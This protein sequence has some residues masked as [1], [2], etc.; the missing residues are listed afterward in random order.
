MHNFKKLCTYIFIYL[1]VCQFIYFILFKNNFLCHK[2][3]RK[4]KVLSLTLR[5]SA[6]QCIYLYLFFLLSAGW[7]INY[8]V[9]ASLQLVPSKGLHVVPCPS[10]EQRQIV[11]VSEMYLT[12][13]A[14]FLWAFRTLYKLYIEDHGTKYVNI[15]KTPISG[16]RL[17][18]VIQI[19]N[20]QFKSKLYAT[21]VV[22]ECNLRPKNLMVNM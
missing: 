16:T 13:A 20:Q 10:P 1:S 12:K 22:T 21:L 17:K 14:Q 8:P 5:K 2:K 6:I 3:K 15:W 7:K 4:K 11:P 19:E 18:C 9:P